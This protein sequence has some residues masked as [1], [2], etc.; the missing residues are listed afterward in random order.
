[1]LIIKGRNGKA[2]ALAKSSYLG[3][4]KLIIETVD[5]RLSTVACSNG[6]YNNISGEEVVSIALP[7]NSV[8]EQDKIIDIL[9]H[10]Y[11]R[12]EGKKKGYVDVIFYLNVDE[13]RVEAF[14]KF[15]EDMMD[16][17]DYV[18]VVLTVQA[19]NEELEY[20]MVW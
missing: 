17:F 16:K 3:S 6:V 1:M 12:G 20:I 9:T 11:E 14:K 2:L 13:D 10:Y 8:Q 4:D 5:L 7:S 19:D 15:E 18:K